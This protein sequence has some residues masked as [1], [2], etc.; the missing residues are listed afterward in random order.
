MTTASHCCVGLCVQLFVV[1]RLI[2][3]TRTADSGL[4]DENLFSAD[5]WRDGISVSCT[6]GC[7]LVTPVSVTER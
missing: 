5:D 7:P 2:Y 6:A 3:Y 1:Q 4:R